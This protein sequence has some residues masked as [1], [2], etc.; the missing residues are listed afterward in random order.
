LH[1]RS[2]DTV[3]RVYDDAGDVIETHEHKASSASFEDFNH[4]VSGRNSLAFVR[5][6]RNTAA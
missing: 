1:Y 4:K 6:Q 5:K 2:H 3:I